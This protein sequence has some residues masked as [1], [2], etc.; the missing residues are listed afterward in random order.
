MPVVDFLFV[1]I[2][3]SSL[4]LTN[5]TEICQSLRFSK[6]WVGHFERKFQT[7]GAS[8]T[9]HCS[10]H[11][12]RVIALSCGIKISAV[13]CLVLSPS[14]RV[15]YRRTDRQNY[16]SYYGNTVL[17]YSCSRGKK[18]GGKCVAPHL[19]VRPTAVCPHLDITCS[20]PRWTCLNDETM[21]PAWA[22]FTQ[23]EYLELAQASGALKHVAIGLPI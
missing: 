13:H 6:G 14:T 16:D 23:G 20:S 2:E 5:H 12:T 15:T 10:Y 17:A 3:L 21:T 19:S 18:G 1:I 8:S 22:L 11:K 4:Y 7:E 9:N